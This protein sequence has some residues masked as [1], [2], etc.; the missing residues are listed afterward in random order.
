MDNRYSRQL[1]FNERFFLGLDDICP[2]VCNQLFLDGTGVLDYERWCKAVEVASAANPGSRLI[3]EGHLGCSRWV[4]SGIT[5]RV[6]EV[7]GSNWDGCGPA[8]APFLMERLP[9]RESPSCEVVLI[10]GPTPRV[11]FR[12]HHGVMDGRGTMTWAEDIFKALRGEEV[13][14]AP[15]TINDY[16]LVRSFQKQLR[17]P[18]PVEHIAP[19]GK[20]QGNE[21]GVVWKRVIIQGKY[22][23]VLG[24]SAKLLA[25]AAWRHSQG[26]VRFGIPVDM[27]PRLGS[28]RST[29]N[30][31]FAIYIEVKPETTPEQIAEDI[32]FQ[33]QH[34]YE[35]MLS[36]GDNLYRYVPIRLL[37]SQT[38][39]IIDARHAR[40]LY[41]LSGCLTNMGRIPVEY[42]QGAGFQATAF[43]GIPPSIEYF[44]LF[45]GMA[46]Y[47]N[48]QAFVLTMPKVLA[49]QGRMD[50]ILDY[51]AQ[52]LQNN[53]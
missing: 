37:A 48:T 12:S 8:G 9:Y 50:E 42:F 17:K 39:K 20:A 29:A 47:G 28:Q 27:R 45:L 35:G 25:Q 18:F 34:G 16:T 14:G 33:T 24:R 15:S 10:H 44:P 5:P 22:P 53:G 32:A 30:L 51:L 49:N 1:S 38:R 41:S 23:K 13:L 36:R 40:G 4:D 19:T 21:I 43:W 11:V 3:L 7:D 46:S 31:A 6:R 52:G 2:P 26:V